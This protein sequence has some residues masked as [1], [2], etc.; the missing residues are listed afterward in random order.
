MANNKKKRKKRKDKHV[1][2][3]KSPINH[4]L[5]FLQ[6]RIYEAAAVASCIQ[7]ASDSM[8]RP[9][10]GKPNI[11]DAASALDDMLGGVAGEMEEMITELG[12]A[13]IAGEDY[14]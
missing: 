10:Q 4:R 5:A 11:T 12:G 2:E 9:S 8:L 7:Y 14:E 1:E 6:G 13:P 3:Q